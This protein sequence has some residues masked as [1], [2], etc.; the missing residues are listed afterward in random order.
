MHKNILSQGQIYKNIHKSKA[1]ADYRFL[2]RL[3]RRSPGRGERCGAVNIDKV[4]RMQNKI[5]IWQN[6]NYEFLLY[7]SEGQYNKLLL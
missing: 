2:M 4:M 5:G 1:L 7:R 3:G 6:F